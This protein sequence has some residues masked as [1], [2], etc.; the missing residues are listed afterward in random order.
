[1]WLVACALALAPLTALTV[2]AEEGETSEPTVAQLQEQIDEL[3]SEITALK[4]RV[5]EL[6]SDDDGDGVDTAVERPGSAIAE[7][8]KERVRSMMQERKVQVCH[9]GNTLHV[10]VNSALA[11]K[12]AGEAE[13]GS[14]ERW[15]KR[16]GWDDDK[17][18]E[19]DESYDDDDD[20]EY[21]DNDADD[22][23]DGEDGEDDADDNTTE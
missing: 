7:K 21:D 14:C 16:K 18:D 6:E 20:D 1:M 23:D 17:D 10:S 11:Y 19:E 5:E 12:R 9:N 8:V 4:K 22:E 13:I 15:N 2:T 3:K